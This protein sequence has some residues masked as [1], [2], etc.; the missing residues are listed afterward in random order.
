MR[1][2]LGRVLVPSPATTA[3]RSAS[4]Q[5]ADPVIGSGDASVRSRGA[6]HD[7]GGLLR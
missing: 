5:Y 2:K 4:A 7:Q 6:S 3:S 1:L